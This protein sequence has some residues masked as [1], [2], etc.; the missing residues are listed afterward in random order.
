MLADIHKQP[1]NAFTTNLMY[2][3]TNP[4]MYKTVPVVTVF[5]SFY[6]Y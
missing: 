3:Y 6:E 5:T 4:A 2:I 1:A